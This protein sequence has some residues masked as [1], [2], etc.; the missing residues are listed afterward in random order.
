MSDAKMNEGSIPAP[1]KR[2]ASALAFD[3]LLWGGVILLLVI[4]FKPAEIDKFPQLFTDTEKTSAFAKLFFKPFTDPQL[5]L[6]MDWELFIDRMWQTIQMALWGTALAIV[7]AIPL[8]LL[9][10]RNIAPVW[11]QQPVRRVLDLIRSIPDLVVALIFITA[12][13]LG[14]FAGV[15]S[16]MFNTGG[17]LAKLFA[18]AV[19]SIDKGPVEG[20]RATGA[21]KLQ[22]IIWGVIP[23]VAPLWTSYALYRFE[24]SSRAAT[25][26]GIIGAGGIGQIL[27]DSINAFQFD[28][29]GCIV[30]VIVVAVSLID[31]LSQVIRTRLL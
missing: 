9:G 16:I 25:V 27:Y 23:Q 31:L 13:G 10:A 15:M 19:E 11:I 26:L 6:S 22:E 21:V 5:F 30:L 28:Q 2:S 24:S 8:G 1:P 17:V 29:T 14:P 4:S 7:L 12:V 20:V 3:T 18:E